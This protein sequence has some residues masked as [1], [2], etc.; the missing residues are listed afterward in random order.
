MRAKIKGEDKVPEVGEYLCQA[1]NSRF[2]YVAGRL[3]CPACGSIDNSVPIYMED[4]PDEEQMYNK[5]DWHAG[6]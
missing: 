5:D 2:K 3:I 6:D 4:D 1:C